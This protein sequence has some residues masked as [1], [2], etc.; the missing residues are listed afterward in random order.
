MSAS[1]APVSS[2]SRKAKVIPHR[3]IISF[4]TTVLD[5]LAGEPMGRHQGP[6]QRSRSADG[7]YA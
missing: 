4:A 3:L 2:P 1:S 6:D 5:D 7:K